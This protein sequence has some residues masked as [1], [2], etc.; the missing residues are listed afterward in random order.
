MSCP[1]IG[2]ICN[3]TVAQIDNPSYL[4]TVEIVCDLGFTLSPDSDHNMMIAQCTDSQQWKLIRVGNETRTV[5]VVQGMDLPTECSS[6]L[7]LIN[8]YTYIKTY[9]YYIMGYFY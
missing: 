7:S 4:S 2:D 1:P 8:V 6:N 5:D 3:A 9:I